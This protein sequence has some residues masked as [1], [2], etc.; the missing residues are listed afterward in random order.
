MRLSTGLIAALLLICSLNF[1][2]IPIFSQSKRPMTFMDVIQHR[3]VGG[4]DVSKDDKR[5]LYTIGTP[6]WKAGKS[7]TD[8]YLA[9]IADGTSR[10][11]T[12]TKDKNETAPRWSPDGKWFA[13]LSD[14]SG[15]NQL[16][17][18]NP[19]G[20]E[21]QKL[22]DHKEAVSAHSFSKNGKY[23]AY[24]MGKPEETQIWIVSLPDGKPTQL[25]K[26]STPVR[27]TGRASGFAEG[28]G[29]T[30]AA[31]LWGPDSRWIYLVGPDSFDKAESQRAD[32]KFDVVIRDPV[33]PPSH[34]WAIDVESKQERRLTEGQELTVGNIRLSPDGQ[35]IGFVGQSP[36]RHE[37]RLDQ[38]HSEI[39]LL[40]VAS[41]K[42]TRV[43]N[44]TIEEGAFSFS[45]DSRWFAFSAA[46]NFEFFRDARVY[47]MPVAGGPTRKLGDEFEGD[48]GISFWSKD[49]SR[50]YFSE[51]LGTNINIYSIDIQT[52]RVS[53]V[54]KETGTVTATREP[55]S[56]T[57]IVNYS[58]PSTPASIYA[59]SVEGLTNRPN[60][61][62]I[63][64]SNPQMAG[65]ALGDYQTVRWR[66]TDGTP[67][68][69]I[70]VKPVGYEKGKRYP[71]IVQLHGGPA[72][73]VVNSF[74]SSYGTYVHVFAGNGYAVLQPNY[75]GSTNYGE[76][77]KRQIS[78]NYFPQAYD[79]IMSGVDYLIKEG[80][81]DPDK[82][83]CMGW[84]AGGHWSN[85]VLTQTNRFKAISSGAGVFNWV[86]MYGQTDTQQNR[87]W[88]IGG[89]VGAYPW[90][91]LDLWL[92]QSPIRYIKN[93]KTPT[94][95]HVGS[96]DP[97]VPRPQSEELH[98]ALKKLGVPTEFIVYPKMP[99]GLT[100]MRYQMVKMVAEF[101]WFEKWI[102][103]KPGWF[104][105][106]PLLDSVAEEKVAEQ[107]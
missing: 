3:T 97:R 40:Q 53:P 42:L 6:D 106:K 13:F 18:M 26:H 64:N 83:G 59:T 56:E 43:T 27:A 90:E 29:P 104:D 23:L 14:R 44:N 93:A 21:A 47:L 71:L 77:F 85:Y 75:R 103:G 20:G 48:V 15:N 19:D 63:V 58:N 91:N 11:M 92:Q 101:N 39:Y 80:I 22:T 86:S 36:D 89:K 55:E 5:V 51:G 30:N 66:S 32:K 9:S 105:W 76:K 62:L 65:I 107:K 96:D 33:L 94:L 95:I 69:G 10:Q 57:V 79:D 38:P 49:A 35:Y 1:S 100:E 37:N 34:L 73:A 45:P 41:K 8:I 72:S 2:P 54:T 87:E 102:K 74:S 4:V 16:Y 81:A 78:T 50:I 82:L 84:S 68:E 67:V 99:H 60:W 7:F 98:M 24:L 52:G 70:L 12:F 88:Y 28:G 61:K 17:L 46:N 25:S 31:L